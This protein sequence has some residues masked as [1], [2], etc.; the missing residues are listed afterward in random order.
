M[1]TIDRTALLVKQCQKHELDQARESFER[2]ANTVEAQTPSDSPFA[3]SA[4]LGKGIRVCADLLKERAAILQDEITIL[5][6]MK[7]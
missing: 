4:L 5:E 7:K 1:N 3:A 6:R 2:L